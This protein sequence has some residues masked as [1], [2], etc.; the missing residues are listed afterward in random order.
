MTE[1]AL[2][3]SRALWNRAELD[4]DSDEVLAQ[5]LDRGEMEAWRALYRL[6]RED[7]DLRRRIVRIAR[8]VPL[9]LPRLWLAA[10]AGL[11]EEI[12]LAAPLPPYYESTSI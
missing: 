10:F 9:P 2:G 8:T 4:L 6:A 7:E 1:P 3:R 5:I 11:G 12:D